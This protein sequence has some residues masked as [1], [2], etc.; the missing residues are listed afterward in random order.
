[1]VVPE[2]L[3]QTARDFPEHIAVY[4][5]AGTMSYAALDGAVRQTAAQLSELGIM[6]GQGVGV[7]GQN[8]SQ[9][10]IMAFAVMECGAVVMPI[11]HE[12]KAGE[13]S[14]IIQTARLHYVLSDRGGMEAIPDPVGP[15]VPTAGAD[16]RLWANPWAGGNRP[17][18]AH[19]DNPA[20][21]RFTSGTT[22]A[23][24]GVILSHTSIIERTEAANKSLHLGP[25]DKVVWVLSMAYHFVVSIILYLRY[26]SAII[27]CRDFLADTI[28]EW[29]NRYG[30][31]FLYASPLHIRLLANDRSERQMPGLRRVISTSTSISKEQCDAFRRRFG[32]PVSQ[33]YGIIEVGL[34]V[35]NMEK[36]TDFPDAIGYA[37]PD[38]EVEILDDAGK[39]LPSG[40]VGHLAMRGPGM[41]DAYLEPPRV[42]AEILQNGWFM[43]GDMASKQPDGLIRVE[44]RKKSMI[45][46]SGNKVF[47]EEVEAVLNGHPNVAASRVSGYVHRLLGECVQAEIVLKPGAAAIDAE[48]IHAWCRGRLSIYKVPQK[49][50]F[51]EE[52]PMTDSG[53][54]KR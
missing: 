39:V 17:F 4:D 21:I 49:V 48:V 37:L 28:I 11:S 25:G 29:T 38:Y 1:M 33:A 20:L 13:L 5:D 34:P 16:W 50:I 10:I 12:L 14:D 30:G 40:Q 36:S 27:I 52:L 9:F 3:H 19:V 15:S 35:I 45:N 43:T 44:G 2:L 32:I 22:G 47:P 41:L 26:G 42:R 51:V 46:V 54:I 53:K 8:S 6:P 24:K 31:T 23:S 7:M 18:A